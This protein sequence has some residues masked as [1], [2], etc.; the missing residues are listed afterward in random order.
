S[1]L[2]LAFSHEEWWQL[3]AIAR[4]HPDRDRTRCDDEPH[5]ARVAAVDAAR[6]ELLEA[7]G[8]RLGNLLLL[9]AVDFPGRQHH[10]AQHFDRGRGERGP[11]PVRIELRGAG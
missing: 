10:A 6:K 5:P 1:R 7:L 9:L 11:L 8:E 2:P 3:A 4:S